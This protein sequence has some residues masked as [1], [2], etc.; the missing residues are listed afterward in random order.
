MGIFCLLFPPFLHMRRIC[1]DVNSY[2]VSCVASRSM[3][4]YR[5]IFLPF[6]MILVLFLL[7]SLFVILF[8]VHVLML[9]VM[10]FSVCVCVCVCVCVYVFLR[11]FLIDVNVLSCDVCFYDHECCEPKANFHLTKF[12]GQ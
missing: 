2:D 4:V 8:S 10:M 3:S 6:V 1:W 11:P 9:T 7:A 5:N 12:N